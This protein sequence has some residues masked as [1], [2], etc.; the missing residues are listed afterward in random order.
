MDLAAVLEVLN[1]SL[2]QCRLAVVPFPWNQTTRLAM[3]LTPGATS[4]LTAE[5]VRKIC[6]ATLVRHE[7]P[8]YIEI[9]ERFSLNAAL[10][11][12]LPALAQRAAKRYAMSQSAMPA[13]GGEFL[14]PDREDDP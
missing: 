3:F 2:P 11:V 4:S 6:R 12:D 5:Q 13:I 10:K 1:R 14:N 8:A 7:V 9:V